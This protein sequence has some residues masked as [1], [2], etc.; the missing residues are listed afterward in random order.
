MGKFF[1]ISRFCGGDNHVVTLLLILIIV[2][3]LL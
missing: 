3:P 2:L 1:G